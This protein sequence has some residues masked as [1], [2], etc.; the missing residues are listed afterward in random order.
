MC[1]G[2]PG[3]HT[4]E[5]FMAGSGQQELEAVDPS[6]R[7]IGGRLVADKTDAVDRGHDRIERGLTHAGA[8]I[9]DTIDRRKADARLSR[10]VSGGWAHRRFA[11]DR[12]GRVHV[13]P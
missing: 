11:S 4:G 2:D 5:E 8:P 12:W 6:A 1:L 10:K 7:Q 13:V 9:Q 3:N